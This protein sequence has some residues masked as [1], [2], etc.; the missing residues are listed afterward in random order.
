MEK[1]GEHCL[2]EVNCAAAGFGKHRMKQALID[3]VILSETK[4]LAEP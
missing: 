1:D 3:D 2:S 4:D